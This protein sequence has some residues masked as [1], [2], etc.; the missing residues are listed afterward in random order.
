MTAQQYRSALAALGLNQEAASRL[1]A[2]HHATARRWAARGVTGT[3][4]ILLRLLAAG[5]VSIQDVRECGQ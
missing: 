3:A 4:A 1:L 5:K 2:V